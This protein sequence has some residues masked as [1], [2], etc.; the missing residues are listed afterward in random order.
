MNV[1]AISSFV[2][3]G[4]VVGGVAFAMIQIRDARAQQKATNALEFMRGIRDAAFQRDMITLEALYQ[5][6]H[7]QVWESLEAEARD[8]GYRTAVAIESI[9]LLVHRRIIPLEIVAETLAVEP[10]WES[11]KPFVE[12]QRKKFGTDGQYEWFE[13]LADRVA[14]FRR[15]QTRDAA[16]VAYRDWKP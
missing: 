14:E 5:H 1:A 6:R 10:I 12:G 15:G 8:A 13:W 9:G 7:E 4:A 3:T 11:L 2:S 16:P